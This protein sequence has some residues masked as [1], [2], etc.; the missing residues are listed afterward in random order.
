MCSRCGGPACMHVKERSNQAAAC[1]PPQVRGTARQERGHIW[2]QGRWQW[3]IATA[4]GSLPGSTALPGWHTAGV[5]TAGESEGSSS[6]HT[7]WPRGVGEGLVGRR[8]QDGKAGVVGARQN[9]H[10]EGSDRDA[11]Q[12]QTQAQAR[13]HTPLTC[14]H[15]HTDEQM[16]LACWLAHKYRQ[17][18]EHHGLAPA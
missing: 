14:G 5:H 15:R 8:R 17:L 16:L 4:H 10:P 9:G 3:G 11:A 6:S 2:G 12:R 7:A 1:L 13:M 18:R